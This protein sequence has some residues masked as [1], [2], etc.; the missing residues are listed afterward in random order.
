MSGLLPVSEALERI[1]A[2]VTQPTETEC[3]S[4]NL[5]VDRFLSEPLIASRHQ[6]P[7]P[8]SAMD[9]YA[10]RAAD[11]VVG[12]P[13]RLAGESAAG[14]G[15]HHALHPG[16]TIRIFTGAPVPEGADTILIQENARAEGEAIFPMQT[17]QNGRFV[18]PAGHDFTIGQTFFERG[19]RL[20]AKDMA[21]AAS[22][23]SATAHVRR[24]PRVAVLATG[25]ELVNPGETPGPDQIIAANHLSI[26]ALAEKAGAESRFLGIAPDNLAALAEAISAAR[27]WKADILVTMGGASVGDHDLVQEALHDAGMALS[28]WRIAMR[29]GKPLMFGALGDMRVLGLPGNPASS[30]VCAELFLKPLIAAFLGVPDAAR[31]RSETGRLGKALPANDQRQDYLRAT[32]AQGDDGV[33]VLTPLPQ[34]DSSLTRVLAEAE[35]LVIRDPFAAAAQAGDLCRFMRMD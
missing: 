9:G 17:E 25:D 13:L 19:Y 21:L 10:V 14:R 34:Q 26:L 16:E 1:V 27:R 30:V 23:G 15:Y 18:R 28:F 29:P 33:P 32:L 7:F 22:L 4:I 12:Q 3:I 8:A 5:A 24:R 31:N 6:P 11:L 35:A 2:S 20:R